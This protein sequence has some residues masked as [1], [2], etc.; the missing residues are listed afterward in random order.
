MFGDSDF[1]RRQI[2]TSRIWQNQSRLE[3]EVIKIVAKETLFI[4]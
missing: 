4:Y 1:C 3:I 2:N